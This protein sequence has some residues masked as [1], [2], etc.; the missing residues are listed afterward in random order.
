MEVFTLK[1]PPL[2]LHDMPVTGEVF[3]PKLSRPNVAYTL[4]LI[5]RLSDT[6]S[7]GYAQKK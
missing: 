2:T 3:T 7:S 6:H 5:L 1:L 4:Y